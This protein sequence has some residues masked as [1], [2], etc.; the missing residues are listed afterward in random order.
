MKTDLQTYWYNEGVKAG[1]T[2]GWMRLDK[3]VLLEDL[4]RHATEDAG[5]LVQQAQESWEETDHFQHYYGNSMGH[6]EDVMSGFD[7]DTYTENKEQ[8]WEGF[9]T[10]SKEK[11]YALARRL[12]NQQAKKL[13]SYSV[14]KKVV[15]KSHKKANSS[16]GGTR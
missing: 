14:G 10:S 13:A 5:E 3:D 7:P 8:F 11:P 16:L 2:D 12:I 9:V 6:S 15:A 1:K 4:E